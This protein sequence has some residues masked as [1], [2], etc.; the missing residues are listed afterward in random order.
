MPIVHDPKTG[1]FSHSGGIASARAARVKAPAVAALP[2][3][4]KVT[5]EATAMAG[6]LDKLHASIA[7]GKLAGVSVGMKHHPDTFYSSSG[8]GAVSGFFANVKSKSGRP[9]TLYD[10]RVTQKVNN[11]TG[12]VHSALFEIRRRVAG[13]T[14]STVL[15]SKSLSE[16]GENPA[17][18]MATLAKSAL[19]EHATPASNATSLHA[20]GAEILGRKR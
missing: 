18:T 19:R 17:K 5:P 9:D 3:A 4:T 12:A 13:N 10:I 7:S 6:G 1:Q 14:D 8:T 2:R 16:L 20:I 15:H 11:S